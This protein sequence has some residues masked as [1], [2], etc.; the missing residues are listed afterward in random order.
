MTLDAYRNL[1]GVGAAVASRAESI[2]DFLH[3]GEHRLVVGYVESP[4]VDSVASPRGLCEPLFVDVD[5]C[6]PSACIGHALRSEA[7]HAA[8]AARDEDDLI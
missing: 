8:S 2:F 4:R 1:G 3:R 6:T 7:T 5:R